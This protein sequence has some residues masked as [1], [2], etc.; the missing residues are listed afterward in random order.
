MST[1]KE[2]VIEAAKSLFEK[3]G[4]K[5]VTM[6]DIAEGAAISRP[7]L[8][9]LY[10]DKDSVFAAC[11]YSHI[12]DFAKEAKEHLQTKQSAERKLQA[13]FDIYIVRPFEWYYKNK[14]SFD[15]MVN[16]S[17]YAPEAMAVY[18]KD[19]EKLLGEILGKQK[20]DVAKVLVSFARD[21]RVYSATPKDLRKLITVAIH[22]AV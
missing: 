16:A 6:I 14:D 11:I 1:N 12:E 17:I 7:T 4:F 19:F 8:Y 3:H 15:M 20:Q 2:T 9:S 18:W 13:V 10:K 21:A 22:M 5:K